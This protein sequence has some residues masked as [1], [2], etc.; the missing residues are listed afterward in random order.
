M[1]NLIEIE[2][3]VSQ[4][5]LNLIEK[6]FIFLEV[7]KKYSNHTIISYKT[8]IFY[9]IDFLFKLKAQKISKKILENLEM[10][11]FRKWLTKNI[12]NGNKNSSNARKLSSLRSFF[13]FLNKN[14]LLKNCE[15]E[16]IKTPKIAKS[17]PKAVDEIDI[18]KIL[19]AIQEQKNKEQWQIKRDFALLTLIYGSGLRIFEALS[20]KKKDFA[21]SEF[22]IIQGKGKKQRMVPILPII[23]SRIQDYLKDCPFEI[24][25]ESEIFVANSG[26]T[27]LARVFSRLIQQIRRKLNLD[28]TITPHAFRHSFATCLLQAGGDLRT[29]QELLGHSSLSTTQRYTKV[30]RG[31]ILSEYQKFTLR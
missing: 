17:L 26:K 28:E 30:D 13:R 22:L 21:N 10:Q 2:E 27:Y 4:E 8:D 15:I 23:N 31:R 24:N 7:E 14:K 25:N 16:K 12:E 1:S 19:E 3:I 5:I 20:L 18:K 11:D 9:F 29:I 6:F